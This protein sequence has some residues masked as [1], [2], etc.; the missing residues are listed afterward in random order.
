MTY[1][2]LAALVLAPPPAA[3]PPPPPAKVVA[4]SAAP[5]RPVIPK[6]RERPEYPYRAEAD[7]FNDFERIVRSDDIGPVIDRHRKR[8]GRD[9]LTGEQLRSRA[10]VLAVLDVIYDS[11]KA[12]RPALIALASI[13]SSLDPAQLDLLVH[14]LRGGT[15]TDY[16]MGEGI[17]KAAVGQ[18]WKTIVR[19]CPALAYVKGDG[20]GAARH[21]LDEGVR[22][23]A[24]GP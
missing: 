9:C 10:D 13:V 8:P 15:F 23:G 12:S 2:L 17:T 22:E 21:V 3:V 18:R 1:A 19:R 20:H 4:V 7:Y 11:P 5:E 24:R 16:A 6:R 14:V